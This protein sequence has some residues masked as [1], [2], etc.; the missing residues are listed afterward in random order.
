[1]KVFVADKLPQESI[2]ELGTLVENVENKPSITASEMDSG[3]GEAQVL[4][5][6]STIV[7][8]EC[9][10]NSP[11]LAL[12]VRAG[13]G[14]NTIDLEAA[15]NAGIYVAN[16]PGKN[17]IAVA[18]LTMGLI[19]SLDR[20]LADN[21]IDFRDGK[22]NKATYGKADGLFGKTIGIVGLGGIGR[23]VVKRAKA[24]GMPVI[25]WSR[26]LTPARA[27]EMDIAHAESVEQVASECDIL[28]VH[29]ALNPETEQIISGEILSKLRD[30]ALFINTARAGVVDEDALFE[31]VRSG[32]IRAG[33]DLLSDE[34]EVKQGPVESRFQELEGAYVSHHIGASTRQAQLAVASDA[35]DIIRGYINEGKVRNWL[36][37]CEHTEA[38]WKLVVRHYDKPGVIANVMNELKKAD[39]NAQELKNVIFDGKK[40]ACCTIQLDTDPSRQVLSNI[41]ERRNEVISATLIPGEN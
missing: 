2:D 22:W 19:I 17:S 34:P 14:V 10:N 27:E 41:R 13:A 33:L 4:V 37:R 24:F 7:S 16:C 1:M 36:N 35:V 39:I 11:N 8:K 15:S 31:E 28:S 26:S 5:V 30:G 6:R 32:R 3:L 38:P 21:V 40:T 20:R 12:I 29:L 25:A 23:E 18:E 9:I